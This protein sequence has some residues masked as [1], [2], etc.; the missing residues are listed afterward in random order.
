MT[1]FQNKN[2][3]IELAQDPK[4]LIFKWKEAH[5][6]MSYEDFQEACCNY[7][8]YAFEHQTKNLLID[9]HNFQLQL[10]DTFKEWQN[11]IHYP[12]YYKL[13]V[14][15]VAYIMPVSAMEYVKDI[16]TENGKF[17]LRNFTQNQEAL[18]WLN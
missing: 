5:R 4:T 14:Q 17:A 3:A 9:T 8:G 1:I 15:K 11:T 2:Y 16:P 6:E 10:P 13:G 7:I 18:S 12:R